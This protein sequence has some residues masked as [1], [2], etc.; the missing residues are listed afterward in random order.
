MAK[1][2][3]VNFGCSAACRIWFCCQ[4]CDLKKS[5]KNPCENAFNAE[6]CKHFWDKE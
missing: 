2:K 5:C 1:I 3:N 6:L 4:D